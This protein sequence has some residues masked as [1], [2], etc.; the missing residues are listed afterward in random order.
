MIEVLCTWAKISQRLVLHAAVSAMRRRR[1]EAAAVKLPTVR[2]ERERPWPMVI[3]TDRL[4]I[5]SF[6]ESDVST[7]AQIVADPEVARFLGDGLPH[8]CEEAAAYVERC[9]SSEAKSGIA[10]Y[11]VILRETGELIGFCGFRQERDYIDFGWR[12]AR[13]PGSGWLPSWAQK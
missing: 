1:A 6:V 4:T 10:R 5:R 11:A 12:F 8:S 3:E 9:I 13:Y 2:A 7:Y